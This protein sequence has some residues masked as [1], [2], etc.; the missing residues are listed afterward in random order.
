MQKILLKEAE[1][2][3]K[4]NQGRRIWRKIV[5]AMACVVVFCTT[6]ALILPAITME[7]NPCDLE[8]HTHGESCYAKVG[9]DTVTMLACTYETLGVHVHTSD[10]YDGEKRLICGQ[11]DYLIHE[12]NE[13]CL[14]EDGTIVCQLPEVSAHVHTDA[15]Y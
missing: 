10:C 5:Q 12:H 7:K 11:A 9:S 6:Y 2:Y 8:E 4:Q 1:Q 3:A 15:C 14:D 13:D